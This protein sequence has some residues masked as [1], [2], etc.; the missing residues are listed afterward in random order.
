MS[1]E[2][3]FHLPTALL[4]GIAYI[5]NVLGWVLRRKFKLNSFNVKMLTI[6][7]YFSIGNA[8]RD[9]NY[10][11]ILNTQEG[12]SSTIDWFKEHWLPV[13]LERKKAGKGSAVMN[14]K[15]N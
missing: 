2:E 7:R 15:K 8:K 13:Y 12:W 10:K 1:L 11:P 6:H 5:C 14:K 4:M 9:L 3:K